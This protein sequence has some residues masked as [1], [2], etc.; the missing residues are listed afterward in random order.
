MIEVCPELHRLLDHLPHNHFPFD[1]ALIPL[2]GIYILNLILRI[3]GVLIFDRKFFGH[4][5]SPGKTIRL[6]ISSVLGF[7]TLI[8]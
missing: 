8:E 1:D 2:N 7:Q 3:Q 5:I 6:E 4:A